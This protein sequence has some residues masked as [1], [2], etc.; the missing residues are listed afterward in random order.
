MRSFRLR[1]GI[2]ALELASGHDGLLRGAPEP[3]LL[4]AAYLLFP[5]DPGAPPPAPPTPGAP[6]GLTLPRPLGRTLVRFSAPR[7]RF[8]AV[9]TL[10]GPL[11]FKARARARENDRILLLVL[12]VEEDSGKE[13]ERLYAHLADAKHLRLWDLDAPVPAPS[14][15]A[16]LIAAPY[17]QGHAAPVRV[18]VLDDGGD[19][20]DTCRGDDFVGAS[21]ALVSTSR[22]EDALRFHVVSADGR[23]DWTAVT[24]VSVD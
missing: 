9:L 8:P 21:A 18:G 24:T 2:T 17:L 12:A 10:R 4:V 20:R 19:L 23:N 3:V 1:L 5:P 16:E 6:A 15:L 11:S 14:T 13:V 22:H 7:G